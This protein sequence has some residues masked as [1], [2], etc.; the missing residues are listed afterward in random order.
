[1]G[2]GGDW[3]ARP[4]S[5]G[6]SYHLGSCDATWGIAARLRGILRGGGSPISEGRWNSCYIY[7][8]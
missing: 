8:I 4:A 1:M 5:D 7:K 3:S 2:L 6:L